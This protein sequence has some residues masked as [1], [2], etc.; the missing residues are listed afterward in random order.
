MTS[1]PRI[2]LQNLWIINNVNN[3][4]KTTENKECNLWLHEWESKL[5]EIGKYICYSVEDR[6]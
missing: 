2:K 5:L 4:A 1:K 3:K 6:F